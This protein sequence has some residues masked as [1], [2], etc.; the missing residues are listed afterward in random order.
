MAGYDEC[1][2]FK[3]KTIEQLK[4]QYEHQRKERQGATC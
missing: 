4:E 1:P 2:N 3:K